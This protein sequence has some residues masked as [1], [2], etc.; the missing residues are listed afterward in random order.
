MK[1]HEINETA[2]FDYR[3]LPANSNE[4]SDFEVSKL[5]KNADITPEYVEW[6]QTTNA[7]LRQQLAEQYRY[8]TEQ[9]NNLINGNNNHFQHN[10]ISRSVSRSSLPHIRCSSDEKDMILT[11]EDMSPKD[12]NR[13]NFSP[14]VK[15]PVP[16]RMTMSNFPT[17]SS[18][19]NIR[20]GSN[21]EEE[22]G[23]F[24]NLGFLSNSM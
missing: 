4:T 18:A 22:R 20:S 23:F 24:G 11:N 12:M 13:N 10:K 1:K 6:L 2:E 21:S 15:R 8:N 7:T 5:D 19:G 14:T 3:E 17:V 16:P 9:Y